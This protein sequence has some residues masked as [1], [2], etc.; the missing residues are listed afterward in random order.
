MYASSFIQN[1]E[2]TI[3]KYAVDANLFRLGS[4]YSKK[5]PAAGF[6]YW[7]ASPLPKK[8]RAEKKKFYNFF[9]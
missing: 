5:N 7:R 8:P 4:T 2:E 3:A 6:F 9:S 1:T